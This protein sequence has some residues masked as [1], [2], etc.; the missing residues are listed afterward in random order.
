MTE[1]KG[2]PRGLS[3]I[4]VFLISL[5]VSFGISFIGYFYLF[6]KIEKKH[7]VVKTPDVRKISLSEAIAKLSSEGLTYNVIDEV[8]NEELVSGTV[9]YQL[10]LPKTNTR[11]GT[12]VALMVSKGVPTVYVPKLKNKTLDEAKEIL[13]Q[14]GFIIGQVKEV[15]SEEVNQEGIVL[16]SYPPEGATA[17]KGSTI[18]LVV[19]KAVVVKKVEMV[20][21]PNVI[22][23]TLVEGQKILQSKGLRLGNVT[24]TT[25]ENFE[26]DIILD[27]NPPAGK[28]VSKGSGVNITLNAETVE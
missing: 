1:T 24:K 19:S 8:E 28:K 18:E 26:F 23:K 15:E 27:Q 17:K 6:P 3:I 7:F 10:P 13:F 21:V 14:L 12:E 2:V 4:I 20:L 9:V 16:D 11:R 5:I 22:G 25:N